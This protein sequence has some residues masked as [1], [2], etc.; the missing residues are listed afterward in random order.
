VSD[1]KIF[2]NPR[3]VSLNLKN[4]AI[5]FPQV[6]ILGIKFSWVDSWNISKYT[7][8]LDNVIIKDICFFKNVTKFEINHLSGKLLGQIQLTQ[9]QEFVIRFYYHPLERSNELEYWR[10]F[11]S[12]HPQLRR[13]VVC[14]DLSPKFFKIVVKD[15]PLLKI[16]KF[17]I[18]ITYKNYDEFVK[19]LGANWSK[20]EE[21]EQILKLPEDLQSDLRERFPDARFKYLYRDR[22]LFLMKIKQ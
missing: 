13:L 9:V 7:S 8:D 18:I 20:F 6:S 2:H 4:L 22:I 17:K 12:K 16:L 21:L 14:P 11:T 3:Q 10:V 5:M 19:L 15:L 1:L